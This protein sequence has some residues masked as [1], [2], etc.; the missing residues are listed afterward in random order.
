M[1]ISL[2]WLKKYVPVTVDTKTL[3]E[4]L[5]MAGLNVERVERRGLSVDHLVVG[6]V[7]EKARHPNADRLSCCRVQVGPNDVRDIVCGAPNVAEGQYVPVALPGA[8]LPNGME[9]KRS[10]I[11]GVTSEGM[12]CS[13]TELGIGEDGSGIIVLR[14]EPEVGAP[15]SNI[16][17]PGDEILEIEITPNRPDLLCHIG[18][19]R[20][21]AAIFRV[22]LERPAEQRDAKSAGKADFEITIEDPADCPRYVGRR[23]SGIRVGPSPEWLVRSLEAVGVQSINN[24]VD[25]TNYV[26]ME[27]GQPLHAFDFR[28][29]EGGKVRVRRARAGERLAA[30]DGKVYE[31]NPEVLAIADENRAVAIAGVIGGEET[32]VGSQ[33]TEVLIESA[34]FHP[35]VVRRGRKILGLS[36]EASYRFE[37]GVDRT[38]CLWAADRAAELIC[39]LAGGTRGPFVDDY[40]VPPDKKVVSIREASV[41][42]ILGTSVSIEDVAAYLGRLQFPVLDRTEESATV[43]VPAHRLDVNEEID[44][45][46]EVARLHGYDRLGAGR[47]FRCTT[48]GQPDEFDLFVDGVADHLAARGFQEVVGSAFTDGRELSEMGWDPGDPRSRPIPILNPLNVHHRYMRTSLVPGMLEIVERNLHQ[49]AKRIKFY[50]VGTVFLAPNGVT[51]LPQETPKLTLVISRPEDADFWRHSKSPLDLFDIKGEVEELL[52]ALRVDLGSDMTYDFDERAGEFRYRTR[53]GIL[54]EGAVV[55]DAVAEKYGFDQPVWHATVDLTI[56]YDERTRP[57]K[58]K[59]LPEFPVSWRDLSLL[60]PP[61]VAYNGIEKAL[62]K[63]AGAL[64]ESLSVFDV[65]G[66]ENIAKGYVAYG[67]RLNFR[68]PDRTLRDEEIDQVID[69]ILVKLKSELGVELRS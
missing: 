8:V 42:R 17:A 67:V 24:I 61:G 20:E 14:G 58:P 11:R 38:R 12:I 51:Q 9:I 19:A 54:V 44:L 22:P 16:L 59:P 4:D 34:N 47:G 13:E 7:L 55:G 10:K 64:L 53:E 57:G 63:H 62:V 6:K 30:L 27:M 45:I 21:V 46:E 18:V 52:N 49:G 26:M 35:T 60:T 48:Y 32:G 31:L 37:R 2:S 68:A 69:R 23:V 15:A 5:T 28:K 40:R 36:T 25:A 50:Q 29:L 3:A 43:E 33:T 66:G 65:Y 1:L 41:R 39:E 56:C